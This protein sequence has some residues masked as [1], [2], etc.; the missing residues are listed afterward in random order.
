MHNLLSFFN[1]VIYVKILEVTLTPVNEEKNYTDS[2]ILCTV[3]AITAVLI[4][5]SIVSNPGPERD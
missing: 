3:H 5:L 2:S 4:C 1:L